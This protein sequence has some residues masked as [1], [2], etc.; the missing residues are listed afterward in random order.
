MAYSVIFPGQGSQEVGMG[1]EFLDKFGVAREVFDLVDESLGYKLS[2]IILEGP[3]EELKKT[4]N[5]Q[6]AIM[7]LSIAIFETLRKEMGIKLEP[8]CV[9]GHSL[10]EYTALVAAGTLTLGDGVRLVHV[11]GKLMQ[12]AVPLGR[13]AMAA[14]LGLDKETI[15]DIC[16]DISSVGVC[17]AANYND[18]GQIVISGEK[19]A[20]EKAIKIAKERGARRAILLKVSAPFHCSLMKPV[21][22]KLRKE[23]EKYTWLSPKWPLVA[24]VSAETEDDVEKIQDS[25]YKQTFMPVLWSASVKKMAEM[26]VNSFVEIGPGAVLSGLVKRTIKGAKTVAIRT[27]DDVPMLKEFISLEE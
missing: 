27:P 13:G 19:E 26:G 6:P 2:K 21:A 14:I 24:N 16:K 10:G 15:N 12:E 22:E 18:P 4:E 3:E 11:R 8:K 7:T 23:F 17:E 20:I 25:L 5:A 9:A 1:K